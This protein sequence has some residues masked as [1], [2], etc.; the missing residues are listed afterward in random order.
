MF[1]FLQCVYTVIIVYIIISPLNSYLYI[2]LIL[3]FKQILLL[4]CPWWNYSVII[5]SICI[6]CKHR[7]QWI[8]Q[9]HILTFKIIE[10]PCRKCNRTHDCIIRSTFPVTSFFYSFLE[11]YNTHA[12]RNQHGWY[13]QSSN[14]WVINQW[15]VDTKVYFR[16]S[17]Q[18]QQIYISGGNLLSR[19]IPGFI[20]F[21][22]AHINFVGFV[23]YL[24]KITVEIRSRMEH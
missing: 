24:F 4:W 17:G 21:Y 19:K 10:F 18:S 9:I 3:D 22:F 13:K 23:I 14:N 2:H 16:D 11:Y 5:L 12:Y 7:S 15:S 8:I 20:W 6:I 1:L